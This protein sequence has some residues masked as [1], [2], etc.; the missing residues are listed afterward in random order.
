LIIG[1]V[2]LVL[3]AGDQ[4]RK[5]NAVRLSEEVRVKEDRAFNE[6]RYA[7]AL[8]AYTEVAEGTTGDRRAVARKNASVAAVELAERHLKAGKPEEA[9]KAARQAVELGPDSAPAYV[10]L[11]RALV[12]QGRVDEAIAE[13][14]KAP[15]AAS[16]TARAG[17]SQQEINIARQAADGIPLWKAEALYE[18][19][20]K[21]MEK[22]PSA[23][24]Q[25]FEETMRVAPKSGHARNAMNQLARM[26]IGGLIPAD[27][28]APGAPGNPS[29][30]PTAPP[31]WDPSYRIF[32]GSGN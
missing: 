20:V 21:Q 5:D 2:W 11:G 7:D 17:A 18:E 9:E 28:A 3:K 19:G 10:A 31:N 15:A 23:A 8:A 30:P 32:G 13:Y 24:K 6:G 12:R 29:G 25:R 27:G 4:V 1:L 14:D 16:R 26:R 22:D